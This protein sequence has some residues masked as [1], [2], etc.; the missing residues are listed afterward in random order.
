MNEVKV[1]TAT[2][3][4]EFES[5]LTEWFKQNYNKEVVSVSHSSY[6]LN[7]PPNGSIPGLTTLNFSAVIVFKAIPF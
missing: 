6:V 2:G 5:R 7:V 4:T 1:I 3:T